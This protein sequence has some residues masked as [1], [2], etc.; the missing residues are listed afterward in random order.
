MNKKRVCIVTPD[1]IGPVKNGGIG[2]HVYYLATMLANNDFDVTIFFTAYTSGQ[3]KKWIEFYKKI[4]INFVS[5]ETIKEEYPIDAD[6]A[7]KISYLTY[8]YLKEKKFDYIH[9]QEWLGNGFCT[10]QSKKTTDNFKNALITVTMHSP[11]DWAREGMGEWSNNYLVDLKTSYY[12]KNCVK[13][14][15]LLLAPSKYMFDWAINNK[16]DLNENRRVVP[17]CYKS[18]KKYNFEEPDISKL[19]FFGRLEKRKGLD[20]FCKAVKNV[21]KTKKIDKIIFLGK[22]GYVDGLRADKY[23][24]QDFKENDSDFKYEILDNLDSFEAMNYIKKEN[25]VVIIASS[26]DNYPYTVVECIE[27]NVNFIASN[28]GGIPEMVDEAVLFDYSIS[29]LTNAILDLDKIKFKKLKHKYS[30]QISESKWLEINNISSLHD[31]KIKDKILEEK[32]LVSLCVTYYNYGKYLPYT[33]DSISK[34]KYSNYEVIIVDDSSNDE[35][36][37]KVLE[38]MKEIYNLPNWHFYKK[39]NGGCA[40]T[41]NYAASMAN[42]EYLIFVDSDNIEMDCT[43]DKF[44]YGMFSSNCDCLSSYFYTFISDEE[45]N[46]NNIIKISTFP[47]DMKEICMLQNVFGDSNLIIKKKVFDEI[48]GFPSERKIYDDW[49]LQMRLSLSGYKVDVIPEKLFYYRESKEGLSRN[50][51]KTISHK[52]VLKYYYEF[53]PDYQRQLF[54]TLVVPM[55]NNSIPGY[56]PLLIKIINIIEKVCPKGSKRYNLLK[57]FRNIF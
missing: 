31:D 6:P 22:I 48:G 54:E 17:N 25:G 37:I 1:V 12:E 16:W 13:N 9:F 57:R 24:K 40:D 53:I 45:A 50:I 36:S 32:P 44:L 47:G 14:C 3:Y 33:L 46:R 10:I 15:D 28:V 43:I 35:Y 56:A 42:G 55:T 38:K 30:N 27:N 34:S 4:N 41:K 2:T 7:L 21:V 11:S 39:T 19:I 5:I 23:I 20:I 29:S 49:V 52:N 8:S 51:N 26:M 18:V